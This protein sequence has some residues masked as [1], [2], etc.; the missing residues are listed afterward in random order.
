M[1]FQRILTG[2]GLMMSAAVAFGNCPLSFKGSDVASVGVYIAPV[3]ESK[4]PVYDYQSARLLTPASVLKSVTVAA[5]LR[6]KRGNYK[7]E[8]RVMAVGKVENGTL[9][10]NILIEGSGDPTLG[11]KYFSEDQPDFIEMVSDALQR[12]GIKQVAGRTIAAVG[13][14]DEGAVPS[15]ELEDIP[16][17]DGAGYYRLNWSDNVFTLMVPS[18]TASPTIPDLKVIWN[19]TPSGLSAWRNPGSTNVTVR[20]QLGRKQSRAA[21]R[22]SMPDP[23]TVLTAKIDSLTHSKGEKITAGGD[24][25]MLLT[26][27]SPALRDVCR[28]LM[29]RSDNQMAEATLRLLAPGRSRSAA[30]TAEKKSLENVPLQYMRIADGSGLSRHNAISAR[31]LANVLRLMARNTDYVS[32][33]ARVGLDGTVRSMMKD[34][35]GR[36]NFVLKSGSMTG[37]VCYCGFKLDPQTKL[38]THVIAIL[39]NNAPDPTDARK[40]IST[41]LSTL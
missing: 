4:A 18:M 29:I 11:S 12:H 23:T 33:F 27:T 22:L 25:I 14:P 15:W 40:A 7:W 30:I 32:S 5:A 21:L 2:L 41:L 19:K 35:P 3:D 16:G 37:V 17:I 26:Y 34:I 24:T 13:W 28:S 31:Q 8:T 6:E 10:G 20:G 39:I 1:N 38:P 36:E 9:R